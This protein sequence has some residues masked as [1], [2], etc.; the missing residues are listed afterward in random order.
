MY[1]CG[2]TVYARGHIGNFRTFVAV[3]VL[4]RVLKH[5]ARLRHAARRQLH[6]RRR[7]HHRRSRRR[8][9]CRCANTPTA[10]LQAFREDTATLGLEAG[11]RE[12]ARHRRGEPARDVRSDRGARSA[13]A[14]LSQRR[15]DLLQDFHRSRLRQAGAARSRRDQVG[16]P[17]RYRQVRQGERPRLRAVEGDQARRTDVG[18]RRRA[19]AVR[20]GTSSA[21]RWRGACSATPSTSTPAAST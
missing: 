19:R 20:A 2:L 6:R 14:H 3:D 17:H 4:R 1:T 7:P 10:G 12:P 9:A 21:R 18:L 13:R 5:E 15:L 11:R 8:P 16:R